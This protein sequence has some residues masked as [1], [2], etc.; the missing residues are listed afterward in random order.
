VSNSHLAVAASA[1][2]PARRNC[3]A[4]SIVAI[5]I[6]S[7]WIC[8]TSA[9]AQGMTDRADRMDR[10]ALRGE[11]DGKTSSEKSADKDFTIGLDLPLRHSSS[12]TSASVDSIVEDRPDRHVTPEVYLKW[13]HQ[14]DWLKASAEVGASV[15]RY[16]KSGDAN[17]DALHSS[18]K[19]AKT[20]GKWEYFVPYASISNEMF[21]LPTFKQA[22]I[23]YNDI[24]AGFYSG[25][26]WRDK[27]LIPYVDAFIP[28]SD[29]SE[30][31]DV[32]IYFDARFGRRMSDSTNYQN[33]FASGKVTASYIISDSW[34][35]E[36]NASIRA[37][38]YG[39][40]HGEK[41]TDVRPSA[42]LGVTWTPDWLKKIVKRSELSLNLEYYRN[43]SNIVDK[44][45]SIW[46]LGPTLSLR[47]KF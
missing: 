12:V 44:N 25:I 6:G 45:Y 11:L 16:F 46:E 38:W 20:D 21:F 27:T 47:T 7:L 28:Y 5:A 17:M 23:T 41:R 34:R 14:Y 24:A 9:Q 42:S 3:R 4:I 30:P 35:V 29:A 22:D 32:S 33:T 1:A 26:A 43:Y 8:A 2:S 18:F 37:R 10:P 36:A 19:L 40:Y 31:G 13:A 15:D 39:D